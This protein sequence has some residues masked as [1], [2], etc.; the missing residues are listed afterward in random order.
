MTARS[1][2]FAWAAVVAGTVA[3]AALMSPPAA[4]L[5]WSGVPAKE[6]VL[7]YPGQASFEWALTQGDHSGSKKFKEG[8][9]CLECHGG[10]EADIGA[11]IASGQKLEPSP[12]PG[13]AGSIKATVQAANDGDR[14][15]VRIV[16]PEP[17]APSGAKMDPDFEV[18]VTMMIDDGTLVESK[19]A[20]CW[21][22][23][24]DDAIGMA[25]AQQGKDITKYFAL[26]RSKMT[27]QGGGEN[28]KS[29]AELDEALKAGK[30]MEFW[31]A[32][33]NKGAAAVSADGYVLDKRHMSQSPLAAAE[34]EFANGT[35]TVVL[36][37]KLAVGQPGRKDIVAGKTY[38]VGFA[39]H[40][41]HAEHRFHH[42]SLGRTLV[43][44]QGD[45][46]LVA[47]KK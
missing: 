42:V 36:S 29:S 38:N 41:A 18:K 19:R 22:T 8:K 28:L 1:R 39:I 37:R 5:D 47:A 6:I 4:A 30:F 12:I 31:Q 7:F 16:W 44:D 40:D 25:S 21:G 10:E 43:L 34:A 32:R 2:S 46:D 26:S 27:R 35:W 45:A 17:A 3:L 33:L 15:Y 23:C 24:H 14:L 11:R 9:T 13:K 20:G